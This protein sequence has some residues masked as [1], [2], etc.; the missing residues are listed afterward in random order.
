MTALLCLPSPEVS[1]ER[2]VRLRV[3][4]W[5]CHL[6]LSLK[7]SERKMEDAVVEVYGLVLQH[8]NCTPA[9]QALFFLATSCTTGIILSLGESHHFIKCTF[10]V[11]KSYSPSATFCHMHDIS[12]YKHVSIEFNLQF[13]NNLPP[14]LSCSNFHDNRSSCSS[15]LSITNHHFFWTIIA[16]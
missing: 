10:H 6:L 13:M 4:S 2:W 16:V 14:S 5:L 1:Q 3:M 7:K 15:K 9:P 12:N 11:L 8:Y